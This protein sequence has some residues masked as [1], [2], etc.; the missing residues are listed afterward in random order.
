MLRKI[1]PNTD[2]IHQEE[3]HKVDVLKGSTKE[4]M[5]SSFRRLSFR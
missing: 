2:K 4:A 3:I 5:R 1:V